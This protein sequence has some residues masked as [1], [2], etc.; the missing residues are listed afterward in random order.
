MARSRRFEAKR[1]PR[2]PRFATRNAL[3]RPSRLE[4]ETC[5]LEVRCSIQ[6]SY[7][8]TGPNMATGGGEGHKPDS[9]SENC[10]P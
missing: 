7:G 8:R 3:V 2:V 4:R 6:L 5:G 1:L 9:E 10:E